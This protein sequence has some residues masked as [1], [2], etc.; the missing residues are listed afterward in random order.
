MQIFWIS[1]LELSFLATFL[2]TLVRN[3]HDTSF[4]QT[5]SADKH[6]YYENY[7]YDTQ[8]V[9]CGYDFVLFLLISYQKLISQRTV[10]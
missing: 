8:K 3:C 2:D 6:E 10:Q 9:A 5:N 4:G 1:M 7:Y